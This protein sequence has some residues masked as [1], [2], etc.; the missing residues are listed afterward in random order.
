VSRRWEAAAVLAAALVGCRKPPP[1]DPAEAAY[2][3]AVELFAKVSGETH[4]LSYRDP[5]FDEVLAALAA[6]PADADLRPKADALTRQI[7]VARSEAEVLD[8]EGNEK[9]A[10][11]LAQPE[12]VPLPK[13][14][15]MPSKGRPGG[16]GA[17]PPPPAVPTWSWAAPVGPGTP[18]L[19]N[20]QLP[21]YYQRHFDNAPPGAAPPAVV[22]PPAADAP[23]P[24]T[25]APPV[26]PG[27]QVRAG[28]PSTTQDSQS[29]PPVYGLPGPAARALRGH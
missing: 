15:P 4:D 14:A 23:G 6:V 28:T 12:F 11:A 29:P 10:T 24:E 19:G 20:R 25:P 13:D 1:D 7:L 8:Q 2:R 21:A 18:G 16:T 22:A 26:P 9:V 17:T 27:P 5:R 3:H